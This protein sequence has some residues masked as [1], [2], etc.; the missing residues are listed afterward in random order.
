[1]VLSFC[2]SNAMVFMHLVDCKANICWFISE[3]K[4]ENVMPAVVVCH[5]LHSTTHAG[6]S[7]GVSR[8]LQNATLKAID[9][10][11]LWA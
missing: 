5:V 2:M 7:S 9:L 8:S 11:C 1:V 4:G 3:T 10:P 6:W